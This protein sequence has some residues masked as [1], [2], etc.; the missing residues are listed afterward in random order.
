MKLSAVFLISVN[1]VAATQMAATAADTASFLQES[2]VGANSTAPPAKQPVAKPTRI[3]H[4]TLRTP[5]ATR[6]ADKRRLVTMTPI[7]DTTAKFRPFV[8]GRYLPSESDLQPKPE[9]SVPS[10]AQSSIAQSVPVS[11]LSGQVSAMYSKVPTTYAGDYVDQLALAA[12]RKVKSIA[13]RYNQ[14]VS[15]K[16]VLPG[17]FGGGAPGVPA[18][19]DLIGADQSSVG[20][21]QSPSAQQPLV[22][23]PTAMQTT[24]VV[25]QP[26]Q[27]QQ[28][29][30]SLPFVA[31]PNLS[32]YEESRLMRL[33]EA[34][35][36][37]RLYAQNINGEMRGS[38]RVNPGLAGVGPPPF[39]LS[40][41]GMPGG[42]MQSPSGAGPGMEARF[43]NWHE[44]D[45]LPTAGFQ[46]YVSPRKMAGPLTVSRSTP[47]QGARNS[48]RTGKQSIALAPASCHTPV[49]SQS[50]HQVA[51]N[52]V[53]PLKSAK[54]S[55]P[56]KSQF[57]ACYPQY[58]RYPNGG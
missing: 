55:A 45:S 13:K 15:K 54:K 27:V 57:V 49:S 31:P 18:L 30:A 51:N 36:P 23:V 47:Q 3:S 4:S 14:A 43:G 34:N 33:V 46:T 39:P 56:V 2:L 58:R 6:P 21:P 35:S 37:E 9:P 5:V 24:A 20:Q 50:S 7:S 1:M 40:L 17:Q 41:G 44:R 52:S 38:S 16:P 25:P 48:R 53:V 12:A 26:Q 19:A 42:G 22:P 8:P 10:I 29:V 11:S 28:R 32:K